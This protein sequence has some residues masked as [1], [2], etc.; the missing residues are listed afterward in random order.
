M[1]TRVLHQF[2]A[3]ASPAD[4]ITDQALMVRGW[5]RDLGFDSEIYSEHIDAGMVSEVKPLNQLR[6]PG[7]RPWLIVH[8]SIGS[9]FVDGLVDRPINLI[10][11]YHNVT[12]AVYFTAS[13]PAWARAMIR[14][15]QQLTQLRQISR[16]AL[17][18][19]PYNEA[20]LI[21]LGFRHTGVLPIALKESNY[22]VPMNQAIAREFGY[23]NGR[24]RPPVILFVGRISPNKKQEDLLKILHYYRRIQPEARLLLVG[25]KWMPA[26]A[27]WIEQLN[28]NL[29][30][31]ES[32]TVT[33]RVSQIDL[34]SYYKVSDLYLSMSEHEGFGKPLIESMYL[35][36]PV[37]AYRSTGVPGTLGGAGILFS[38][39]D[40][41]ALAEVVDILLMNQ[42]LRERIIV[43]QRE[44]VQDFLEY[45]IKDK[46]K[47]YLADLGLV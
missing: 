13:D 31:A 9:S 37:M 39:K 30:L 41:E 34:V 29:G 23:E 6:L 19:S 18:D 11:M 1:K 17:G 25:E 22:Q 15:R 14:G 40:F 24:D 20:E 27:R 4:A 38:K 46:L 3:G 16:L 7:G 42:P 12:P 45:R 21:E 43:N 47:G 10:L 28:E 35:D 32:V 44:R 5:L 2:I 33:G 8:Q 26:Y 36:L